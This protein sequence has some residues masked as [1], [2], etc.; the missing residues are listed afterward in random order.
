MTYTELQRR[1]DDTKTKG[2]GIGK[3]VRQ[4]LVQALEQDRV[5]FGILRCV[6]ILERDADNVMVCILPQGKARDAAVRIQH[7]LIEAFC[8]ENDVRCLKVDCATKISTV[9][10]SAS[11][12]EQKERA[13]S[14]DLSCLLVMTPPAAASKE[15]E[16]VCDY[17]ENFML[18]GVVPH[19]CV[20]IPV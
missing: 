15:D 17:C 8:R 6:D 4:T 11:T 20:E 19:G 2:S 7:T 13:V 9:F 18:G 1:M 5:R 10:T 12:K 16:F 14:A 3:A